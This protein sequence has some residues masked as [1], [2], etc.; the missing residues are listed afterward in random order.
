MFTEFCRRLKEEKGTVLVLT[1]VSMVFLVGLMALVT[2]AGILYVN[3]IK[4]VNALDTAVLAGAQELPANTD[5][6]RSNAVNYAALNGVNDQEAGFEILDDNK[7]IAASGTRSINLFFAR[8]L[9]HNTGQVSANAKAHISPAAAATGV[10][11]FGV[12]EDNFLYGQ[13]VILKEGAGDG[14]TTR[15]WFGALSLGGNGASIYSDNLMYGYSGKVEVG[16]EFITES[17]NMSQPTKTAVEYIISQCHDGC[18]PSSYDKDCPKILIVPIVRVLT[19]NPAGFVFE[20]KVV[21]FGAFMVDSFVGNGN[22]NWVKGSFIRYVISGEGS[23][24]G[25]DFGLYSAQLSE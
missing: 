23:D 17:G 13:E 4:L 5:A 24:T 8:I 18:T 6:A 16:D 19:I 11:P 9:G 1:A 25:T 22:D 3:R 2:D 14:T 15:G 21:G 20:V 12:I 10:A 7:T